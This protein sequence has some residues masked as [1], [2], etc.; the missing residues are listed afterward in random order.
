MCWKTNLQP[1]NHKII[2]HLATNHKIVNHLNYRKRYKP[3]A[4]DRVEVSY[5]RCDYENSKVFLEQG[6]V[7]VRQQCWHMFS[8]LWFTTNFCMLNHL[9]K[10]NLILVCKCHNKLESVAWRTET[11]YRQVGGASNVFSGCI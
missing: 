9:C 11:Q 2:N 6:F 4:V 10:C 8:F 1:T 7:N 5:G 3:L